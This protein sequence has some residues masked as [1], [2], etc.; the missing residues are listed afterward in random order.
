MEHERLQ[1]LESQ[2]R[3]RRAAFRAEWFAQNGPCQACGSWDE[4]ELD[5]VDPATKD[6]RL[7]AGGGPWNWAK[8]RRAAE[9][10]KC[11]ALCKPCHK[12]KS[13]R[14]NSGCRSECGTRAKYDHGCRCEA[15]V[16]ASRAYG[17]QQYERAKGRI[18]TVR[19]IL[20]H[21]TG[22][23]Y[24]RHKCRCD[25]CVAWNKE[26]KRQAYLLKKGKKS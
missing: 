15:C 25:E 12:A 3:A 19:G 17:R 2:W 13:V 8:E 7:K 16:E 14:E 20:K 9:L 11:Q 5:H 10:A 4:L 26:T 22:N 6:P 24:I 21:A 18:P 23:A 1:R